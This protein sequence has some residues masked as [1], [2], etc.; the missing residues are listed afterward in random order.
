[1]KKTLKYYSKDGTLIEFKKYTIDEHG[2]IR[3]MGGKTLSYRQTKDEY[4]QCSVSDDSGK[5]RSIRVARA[6]ASTFIGPPPTP[7][8]TVD[9][10]Y[11]NRQND[12]LENIRWLCK[13]GQINNRD[14]P[15]TSKSAVIIVKNGE[16]KTSQE[17]INHLKDEKNRLGR[18]YTRH[19]INDYARKKQHGFSYKEYQ[20]LPG[21]I[22]KEIIGS[23]NKIGHWEISDMNR[24]KYITK[25]TE[26]VLS[27]ERFGLTN[28]YPRIA[29]NGKNFLC[30][31]LS[32]MTFFPDKW[33]NKKQ[34]E[35]IL[36]E[37]DDPLDFRPHK[38]RLGTVSENVN[39]AHDNGKYDDTKSARMKCAS[40]IKGILEKEHVSQEAAVKYLI[41]K[42][43]AKACVTGVGQALSGSRHTAYGRTWKRTI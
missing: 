4:N 34:D 27:G 29:I 13:S 17:W 21:E 20:D 36:H 15:E 39:D 40:Y 10:I 19:M 41:T 23:E 43:H 24:V 12:T 5:Q 22:W 1:M 9:H 8:H 42:G 31:I 25:Y 26:N 2:V 33:S 18:D 30:H 14:I 6:I 28:G 37:D 32:F 11:K 16:E 38:L 7:G 3:N 35:L